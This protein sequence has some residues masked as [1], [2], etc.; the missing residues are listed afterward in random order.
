MLTICGTNYK[1]HDRSTLHSVP[2][3]PRGERSD[4]WLGIQHGELV[5]SLTTAIQQLFGFRPLNEKYLVSPNGAGLIGGFELGQYSV[6]NPDAHKGIRPVLMCS[7]PQE[8]GAAIGFTHSNDSRQQLNVVAGGRVFLCSN[9]VVAG[10]TKMKRRHTTGL[11]L[12]DWLLEGLKG[13]WDGLKSGFD[14]LASLRD[15]RINPRQH[16]D[17][18][19]RLGRSHI[20]PWRLVGVADTL[21]NKSNHLFSPA[22]LEEQTT[23]TNNADKWGWQS[24]AWDWYNTV[25][26]IIKR[27]SPAVQ[28]R[29][30]TMLTNLC[31]NP[32]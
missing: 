18:L 6:G 20:L 16:D 19:L 14:R 9:G 12:L 21:W 24:S 7:E 31:L 8:V 32:T 26:H 2:V 5:D 25:T 1:T 3:T 28:Y 27:L 29:S 30:L 15:V 22:W 23:G 4:R 17:N 11:K 13:F 10:E